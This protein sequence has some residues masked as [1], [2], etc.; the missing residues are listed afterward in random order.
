M[1]APRPSTTLSSVAPRGLARPRAVLLAAV[2]ALGVALAA[3]AARRTLA[4]AGS[5]RVGA[6]LWV[7]VEALAVVAL[8]LPYARAL[9]EGGASARCRLE[10]DVADAPVRIRFPRR[11][12]GAHVDAEDDGWGRTS[13]APDDVTPWSPERDGEG[14]RGR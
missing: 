2:L 13:W 10:R 14:P 3:A 12:V 4:M 1:S 11:R 6:F 8:F 7:G 9:R 5:S